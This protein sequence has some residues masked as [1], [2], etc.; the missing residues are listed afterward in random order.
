VEF[1]HEEGGQGEAAGADA[2][3]GGAA[4]LGEAGCGEE[5]GVGEDGDGVEGWEA[6][7]VEDGGEGGREGG[8]LGRCGA[9][10][11]VGE[12]CLVWFADVAQDACEDPEPAL[13]GFGA[14]DGWVEAFLWEWEAG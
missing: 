2:D 12:A 3:G 4:D 5:G 8:G 1:H 10:E 14:G 9:A 13:F 11:G 7:V 6:G